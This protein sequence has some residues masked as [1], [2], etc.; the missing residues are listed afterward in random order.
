MGRPPNTDA[1]RAQIVRA[2]GDVMATRGYEGAT[3]ARVAEQAGL[4]PG[5]VHYHFESKLE[6]LIALADELAMAARGRIDLRSGHAAPD[7]DAQ[8]DA[9][10]DGLL[11]TGDD[12]EPGGVACWTLIGA[13]AVLR[14]EVRAIYAP[15]VA[16]MIDRLRRRVVAVCHAHGRSGEGAGAIAAALV[17]TIEGYFAVA[18][19]A[20]EAIPRGSAAPMA[21]R[22]AAGLCAAQ[23]RRER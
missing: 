4:A 5:L 19:A 21:K 16:E 13:E 9:F 3:V 12:A 18:A 17:A 23:P 14:G 1:R 8:L 11:A 15:F 2:F 10:L 7:P 6:I 20:P 22:M